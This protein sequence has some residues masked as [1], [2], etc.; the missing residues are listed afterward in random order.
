VGYD[1]PSRAQPEAQVPLRLHWEAI[2]PLTDLEINW[3]VLPGEVAPT[4]GLAWSQSALGQGEYPTTS[5]RPKERVITTHSLPMPTEG[6]R[7]RVQVA[8]RERLPGASPIPFVPRWLDHETTV[9]ELPAIRLAGLPAGATNYADRILLLDS[10]LSAYQDRELTPGAPVELTIVWQAAREMEHDYTLFLQ[11]LAPDGT[12]KGQID[13]WPRD[14]THPTSR[15]VEG[16]PIEDRYRVYLD[17]DAPPG[18]YQVAVGWYLLQTMERLPVL[19]DDGQP[20]DDK[21]TL[22]GPI[23]S[24]APG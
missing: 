5:W 16:E 23:V 21:I 20:Y 7:A 10:D 2:A 9:L 18:Q 19:R 12:L 15:W 3:R 22:P 17:A 13:V 6:E 4:S 24:G 14:G 8:V 11:L 1:L